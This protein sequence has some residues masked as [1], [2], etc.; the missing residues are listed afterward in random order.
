MHAGKRPA[1]RMARGFTLVELFLVIVIIGALAALL[2]PSVFHASQKARALECQN[3]LHQIYLG[4]E[5]YRIANEGLYPFVADLPSLKL[6]KMPALCDVLK[7]YTGNPN[8]FKCPSDNHRRFEMEGSSY[9]FTQSPRVAGQRVMQGAWMQ[10][11]GSTAIPLMWDYE[12]FH[13]DAGKPASRNFVYV[14][15]HVGASHGLP[16]DNSTN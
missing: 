7:P 11:L 8:V 10:R 12:D 14:D 1:G 16:T 9:E 4:L 13:G 15:G 3:N 6:N 2:M 5:Q